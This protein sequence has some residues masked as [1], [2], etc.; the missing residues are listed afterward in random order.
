MRRDR[1]ASTIEWA[2]LT[3]I[4]VIV[5]M[6]VIQFALVYHARQVA[7]AAAQSGARTARTQ[8]T[9]DWQGAAEARARAGVAQIGPELITPLS[10]QAGGNADERWV[11]VS[12][13]AVSLVP[14]M[15]FK[16]HERSG[17]PIECYRPDVGEGTTCEP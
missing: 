6:T 4:L 9:G 5:I 13:S 11:E 2:L 16:V 14:F 8:V 15:T 1:G 10:V 3:P 12:G 17:G 7:L